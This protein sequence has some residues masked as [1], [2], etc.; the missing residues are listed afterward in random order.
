MLLILSIS[1]CD[2]C[3]EEKACK[4]SE[5]AGWYFLCKSFRPASLQGNFFFYFQ[6]KILKILIILIYFFYFRGNTMYLYTVMGKSA[7]KST[8]VFA[9]YITAQNS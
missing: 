4:T 9:F 7:E 3:A 2:F 8:L 6:G 5:S 1:L